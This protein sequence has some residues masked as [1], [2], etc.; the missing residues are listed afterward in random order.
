MQNSR[1]DGI[2]L[3]WSSRIYSQRENNRAVVAHGKEESPG[4]GA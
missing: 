1:T 2:L 4:Q 3:I